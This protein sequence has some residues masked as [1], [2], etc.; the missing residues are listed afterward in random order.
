MACAAFAFPWGQLPW[1]GEGP[2]IIDTVT[3]ASPWA[4]RQPVPTDI[5]CGDV[6][7]DHVL[8]MGNC[9]D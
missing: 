5:V 2:M 3:M 6:E 7:P 4:G 9:G 8:I 1:F